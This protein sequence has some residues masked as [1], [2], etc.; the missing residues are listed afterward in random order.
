MFACNLEQ[1]LESTDYFITGACPRR[2]WN[3]NPPFIIRLY[4]QF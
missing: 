3:Y 4:A 2:A 1:F